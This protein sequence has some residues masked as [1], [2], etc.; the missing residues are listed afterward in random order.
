M[1]HSVCCSWTVNTG[2]K[3]RQRQ[4]DRE[5]ERQRDREHVDGAD[6]RAFRRRPNLRHVTARTPLEDLVTVAQKFCHA[7]IVWVPQRFDCWVG[8]LVLL[9]AQRPCALVVLVDRS[10][11][12]G[13]IDSVLAN[14]AWAQ[15]NEPRESEKGRNDG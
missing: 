2:K 12:S 1:L 6:R 5:T 3:E 8:E 10:A 4:R 11:L 7:Q 14:L 9:P 15:W 13:S